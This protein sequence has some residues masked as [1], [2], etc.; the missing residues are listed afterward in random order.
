M[1]LEGEEK[2][3][4][5]DLKLQSQ[6]I[7]ALIDNKTYFPAYHMNKKHWVTVLLSNN[8]NCEEIFRLIDTSYML[9]K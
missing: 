3:E 4:V 9:A 8:S 7:E 1:G 6:K 2:V 5:L